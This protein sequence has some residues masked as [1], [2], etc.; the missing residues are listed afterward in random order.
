MHAQLCTQIVLTKHAVRKK[1]YG[2]KQKDIE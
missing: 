2:K 1:K